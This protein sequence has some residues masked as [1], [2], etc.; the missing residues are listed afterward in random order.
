V[1]CRV[2]GDDEKDTRRLNVCVAGSDRPVASIHEWP[3][4]PLL[5]N[6]EGLRIGKRAVGCRTLLLCLVD[7]A[8]KNTKK[9]MLSGTAYPR[10]EVIGLYHRCPTVEERLLEQH[11]Y[12]APNND[13]QDVETQPQGPSVH[14]LRLACY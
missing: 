2:E 12:H 14:Q 5:G 11:N 3:R 8:S 1:G 4:R 6:S 13:E 10:G 9:H 7:V